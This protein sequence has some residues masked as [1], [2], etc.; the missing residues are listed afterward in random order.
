MPLLVE[1]DSEPICAF[2]GLMGEGPLTARILE[3]R[4]RIG[5]DALIIRVEVCC[6]G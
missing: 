5:S 2:D 3:R 4:E 1:V 6:E